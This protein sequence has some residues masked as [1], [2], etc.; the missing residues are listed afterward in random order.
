[1]PRL[2]IAGR[3]RYEVIVIPHHAIGR[4]R[5]RPQTAEHQVSISMAELEAK[6]GLIVISFEMVLPAKADSGPGIAARTDGLGRE[7]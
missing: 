7:I 2:D 3:T 6:G 4:F 1:M 5:L